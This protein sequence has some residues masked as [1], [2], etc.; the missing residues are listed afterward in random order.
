MRRA[1]D[2][3]RLVWSGEGGR[4]CWVGSTSNPCSWPSSDEGEV[5]VA[6]SGTHTSI[7]CFSTSFDEEFVCDSFRVFSSLTSDFN[8]MGGNFEIPSGHSE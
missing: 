2:L 3:G 6:A 8:R 7:V 5:T 1:G 4:T